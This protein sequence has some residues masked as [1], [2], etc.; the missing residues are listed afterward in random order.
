MPAGKVSCLLLA[1]VAI[2]FSEMEPFFAILVKKA[3]DECFYEIILKLGHTGLGGDV[4]QSVFFFS[5]FSSGATILF[6]QAESF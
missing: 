6:S 5:I 2:L 4:I 3:Q 1:L